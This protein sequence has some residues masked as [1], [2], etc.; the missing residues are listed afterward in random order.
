[1]MHLNTAK[2]FMINIE[3]IQILMIISIL[4]KYGSKSIFSF[5][6]LYSSV[7]KAKSTGHRFKTNNIILIIFKTHNFHVDQHLHVT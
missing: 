3:Y 4:D 7:W 2:R 1:M 6:N 5:L